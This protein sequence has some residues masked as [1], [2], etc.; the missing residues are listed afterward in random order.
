MKIAKKAAVLA[1]GAS[2][3]LLSAC[4]EEQL[5]EDVY[6][7]SIE[8]MEQIDSVY[9]THSDTLSAEQ[10]T[11]SSFA[12]G[13]VQYDEPLQAYIE[14]NMNVIDVNEAVELDFRVNGDDVEVRE[15]KEWEDHDTNADEL[16]PLIKPTEDMRFF[17]EFEDEFLMKEEEEYYEVSFKGT[18]ERHV[19]LVEKKLQSLG[20]ID[21]DGL[22][23]EEQSSIQL[24]RIDM[25]AYINKDDM[26]LRGYDSRFTFTIELAGELQ[27]F[28][29]TSSVRY[30]DYNEA[31]G[32][33]E[34]FIEEKIK[35]IQQEQM[36]A[37][38][39]EDNEE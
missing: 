10:Q 28:N 3:V 4:G 16:Q 11:V 1:A 39:E 6:K 7:Q 5:P 26:R 21:G 9:F 22:G 29:E 25:A 2:V 33:L 32:D 31:E 8:E 24:D 38:E 34:T 20:V 37:E 15:N 13:A 17:L 12:R 36:Q 35:E 19:S 18:D 27:T 23:E 30:D 14:S